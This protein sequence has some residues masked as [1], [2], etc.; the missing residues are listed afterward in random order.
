MR[1]ADF[2][3]WSGP[4]VGLVAGAGIGLKIN[5]DP[6]QPFGLILGMVLGGLAGCI[7]LLFDTDHGE[8]H[9]EEI[10]A[11]LGEGDEKLPSGLVERF[12]AAA[13]I[14]LC[15]TPFLGFLLNLLGYF[16]NRNRSGWAHYTPVFGM[17]IGLLVCAI[18][19]VAIVLD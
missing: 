5:V 4:L 6:P 7:I 16:L 10:P 11:F 18:A 14:L 8:D 3:R 15:W 1:D 19:L 9:A 17:F 2:P 13:G 12:V